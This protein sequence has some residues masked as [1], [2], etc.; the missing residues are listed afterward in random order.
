MTP[1]ALLQHFQLASMA[2]LSLRDLMLRKC[3]FSFPLRHSILFFRHMHLH[4]AWRMWK[5]Q[6]LV[7]RRETLASLSRPFNVYPLSHGICEQH[8]LLNDLSASVSW[9]RWGCI[10]WFQGC[11]FV[12]FL[13]NLKWMNMNTCWRSMLHENI[14]RERPSVGHIIHRALSAIVRE[15]TRYSSSITSTSAFSSCEVRCSHCIRNIVWTNSKLS[16]D[17]NT[18]HRCQICFCSSHSLPTHILSFHWFSH[19]NA[20]LQRKVNATSDSR[21]H[22]D[23]RNLPSARSSNF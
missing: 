9:A 18:F 20:L 15:I 4:F 13:L 12:F 1:L 19:V 11:I 5:Q 22:I 3:D 8:G 2:H 23:S 21:E 16:F 14:A 10:E 7:C 6:L 17:L